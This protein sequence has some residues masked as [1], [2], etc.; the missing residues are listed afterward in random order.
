MFVGLSH[1]HKEALNYLN[2]RKATLLVKTIG[3]LFLDRHRE[4]ANVNVNFV[5]PRVW[6]MIDISV[7]VWQWR[8]PG[9]SQTPGQRWFDV[10]DFDAWGGDWWCVESKWEKHTVMNEMEIE[11]LSNRR[12]GKLRAD[13]SQR[14][15]LDKESEVSCSRCGRANTVTVR[16]WWIKP[17]NSCN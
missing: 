15:I 17:K 9:R 7:W 14:W 3:Y 16:G 11:Y 12:Q 6:W 13:L 8:H 10:I 1:S 4:I 5:R 2:Q